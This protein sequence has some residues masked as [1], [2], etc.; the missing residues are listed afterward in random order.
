MDAETDT[1]PA[2]GTDDARALSLDEAAALD[3][4][5]GA[6]PEGDLD[7][8]APEE[9][10]ADTDADSD[11]EPE[12]EGSEEQGDEAP[13]P[14]EEPADTTSVTVN[15]EKITLADLK[16]GYLRQ[17]DYSRKTQAVATQRKD[18]E[19]MSARMEQSANA[20]ASFLAQQVPDAPHPSMAQTDPAGYVRQKAAHEA[21]LAQVHTVFSQ[22]AQV[23]GTRNTLNQQQH[24]ELLAQENAKLAKAFPQTA[25]EAGRKAFFDEAASAARDLG[26]SAEDISQAADHRMF[27]LAH[28]AAIGLRAE[29]AKAK[30]AQKVANVPPVAQPKRQKTPE[31]ARAAKNRDAMSRLGRTG[32]IE[33]AMAIDFN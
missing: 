9:A 26:Y 31:A 25:T 2:G 1:L 16:G 23:Q 27:A 29:Q 28:Y 15:G 13:P 8:D 18:L 32:S 6:E 5:E 30:A 11:A 20:L 3:I 4:N 33:D 22:V 10:P 19:A 17:A 21:A 7:A 12:D 24:T 14:L